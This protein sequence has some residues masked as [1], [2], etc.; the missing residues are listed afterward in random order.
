MDCCSIANVC[1][2]SFVASLSSILGVLALY[3]KLK[4]KK[5]L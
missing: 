3:I 2:V 4:M 5:K 1:M